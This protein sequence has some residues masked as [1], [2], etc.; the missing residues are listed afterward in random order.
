MKYL[1]KQGEYDLVII[2]PIYKVYATEGVSENDATEV[3][4]IMHKLDEVIREVNATIVYV[5]H[6][7]KGSP[8][9]RAATDRGSGSGVIA[10]DYDASII[11]TPH[12]IEDDAVVFEAVTRDY[13]RPKPFVADWSPFRF[14]L[15]PDL[16]PDKMTSRSAREKRNA[17]PSAN[18][19][20]EYMLELL[21]NEGP[22]EVA[23]LKAKTGQEMS[24]CS[25]AA[26]GR[27]VA[28]IEKVD[29]HAA[30][31]QDGRKHMIGLSGQRPE[32]KSE[33]E[34]PKAPVITSEKIRTYVVDLLTEPMSHGDLV[35]E[36]KRQIDTS[37][38]CVGKDRIKDAIKSLERD[39]VVHRKQEKQQ[40]IVYLSDPV[41][42]VVTDES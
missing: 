27:A 20:E 26:I 13:A 18:E 17:G 30:R 25:E 21:E 23:K 22:M 7:T 12:A 35:S 40:R 39:G 14:D 6:D 2:D 34:K 31:W 24:G 29:G 9:D 32:E 36:T 1:A 4:R 16:Y 33:P 10:R 5:I 15:R 28:S 38:G 11:L 41:I 8:G 19:I 37:G 3:A 42:E